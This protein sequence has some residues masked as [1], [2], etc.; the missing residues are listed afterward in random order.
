VDIGDGGCKGLNY[1]ILA[2]AFYND[3]DKV[4]YLK[5]SAEFWKVP[6]TFYGFDE[7]YKGWHNIQ[8]ERLIQEIEKVNTEWIIYT[9]ASDAIINGPDHG[10]DFKESWGDIVMSWESDKEVCAGGW[11]AKKE[12]ILST[13]SWLKDFEVC[14]LCR[15]DGMN[16]Q[17]KWRCAVRWGLEVKPDKYREIFQVADEPL[18][19]KEGRVYNPRTHT[20]PFIVHWAG[21]YTDPVVGKAA[22]IE[23]TWSQLGF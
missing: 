2:P 21:G 23:P 9:D 12:V 18:E 6:I 5:K 7:V 19:I 13:L 17:V 11:L 1:T 3:W 16:P 22:L 10:K 14:S 8:I 4:R 15:R 20:F